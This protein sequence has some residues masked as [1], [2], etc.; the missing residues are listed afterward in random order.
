M[1]TT[2][3][4]CSRAEAKAYAERMQSPLE[5]VR[6]PHPPVTCRCLQHTC[7]RKCCSLAATAASRWVN[8]TSS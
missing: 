8:S 7:G 2:S 3:V 1:A 6:R 5:K 4:A